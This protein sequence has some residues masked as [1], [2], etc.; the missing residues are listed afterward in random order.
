MKKNIK[1]KYII[2]AAV[3]AVTGLLGGCADHIEPVP[4]ISPVETRVE[5]A[6]A[7]I[8]VRGVVES[9]ESRN[10]YSALGF[11][12]ERVYAEV[13]DRVT[14]GQTLAVLDSESLRLTI[15]QQRALLELSRANSQNLLRDTQRRLAEAS[16]NLANNTNMQILNAEAALTAA[17]INLE[18]AERAREDAL[19]DSRAGTDLQV[20]SAKTA[21]NFARIEFSS[22]VIAHNNN[23]A[24]YTAGFV[25]SEALRLSEDAL[26]HARNAY[27]D[28]I[29]NHERALENE[30]R[31]LESLKT[32]RSSAASS[33]S[34]AYAM[35]L[36]ARTAARQ[37]VESLRSAAAAAETAAN[38]E[39]ME[40]A[41]L[42]MEKDLE[43]SIITAP[44]GGTLTAVTAR[45]GAAGAGLLFVI[46]DTENLRIITSF[47]EYDI[48]RVHEGME[49][50]IRTDAADS[51]VY[52]GVISRINPAAGTDAP[53]VEFEAEVMI[54]SEAAGLLIGMN[55]RVDVRFD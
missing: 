23:K 10:V 43:D 12:I 41:L 40:I 20:L 22:A 48:A 37:E 53:V 49:V 34:A 38:L 35:L 11:S 8:S 55:T 45:E 28:A 4:V 9:V 25:S 17:E 18:A 51:A 30:R 39:H 46:E 27:S 24:L 2:S 47:R 6:P 3:F 5:A 31:N 44:I 21:L 16:A 52:R 7:V 1:F 14:Q 29:T 33:R 15:E 54:T 13:G 42:Q 32:A 36:A 50:S 26:A 19:R